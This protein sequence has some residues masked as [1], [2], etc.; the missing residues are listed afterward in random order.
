MQ[1]ILKL[2]LDTNCIINLLDHSSTTATSVEDLSELIRLGLSGEVNIAVTTRL[3][4]DLRNDSNHVR[5]ASMVKS[6]QMFPVIGTLARFDVSVFDGGDML[7]G[8]ETGRL[9]SELQTMLFPGGL[10]RNSPTFTNK[11]NDV[12]HLVGHLINGRDVF[13][14]DDRGIL[15]KKEALRASPGIT[16]LSPHDALAL[17]ESI[18]NNH[19]TAPVMKTFDPRY[20]SA[21]HRGVVTFDYSNN[22]G[23]FLI[24]SGAY[25][26]VTKWS[27]A[28]DKAIYAYNDHAGIE[29]IA[30]AKGVTNITDI[31]DVAAY[32]YSSRA[33]SVREGQIV[34]FKNRNGAYAAVKVVDVGDDTRGAE[35]D[36]LTFEY[37]IAEIGMTNFAMALQP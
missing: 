10:D 37:Q 3:E 36:S 34:I 15:R 2:T 12:D 18:R 23:E 13:V 27:K 19:A 8:A 21:S 24:G 17:I 1:G 31:V 20:I 22:G 30:L 14:T 28:S 35:S 7:G 6:A 33:R 25:E 5:R 29:S 11:I 32:N 4:A 9:E 26:F 16:V